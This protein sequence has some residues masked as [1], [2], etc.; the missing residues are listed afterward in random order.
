MSGDNPLPP[1]PASFNWMRHGTIVLVVTLTLIGAQTLIRSIWGA[2]PGIPQVTPLAPASSYIPTPDNEAK[3]NRFVSD[4]LLFVLLHEMGHM[5]ISEFHV[6]VLGREEDAADRFAAAVMTGNLSD[7]PEAK[8]HSLL[9][10]GLFWDAWHRSEQTSA[11]GQ[12]NW[13]DEHGQHEQR[14]Y[15]IVCLLYGAAPQRY[16][17]VAQHAALEPSRRQ[18]CIR[19]AAKNRTDWGGVISSSL[20]TP[21]GVI[22]EMSSPIVAVIYRPIDGGLTESQRAALSHERQVAES[23]KILDLIASQI[24]LLQKPVEENGGVV[25]LRRTPVLSGLEMLI[26]LHRHV[27]HPDPANLALLDLYDYTV[28]GDS[29]LNNNKQPIINAFWNAKSRSITLCYSLVGMI[30]NFGKSIISTPP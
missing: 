8:T 22:P 7:G 28:I 9:S 15:A 4:V 24:K 23:L 21:K 19:E 20:N 30:E 26:D 14:A 25:R 3:L 18:S 27:Q 2:N 17:E 6:P 10:V 11:P 16:A 13:A 1:R 12:Y 5:V 29:C